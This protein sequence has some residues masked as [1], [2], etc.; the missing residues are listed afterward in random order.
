MIT[1]V[2]FWIKEIQAMRNWLY[3][4]IDEASLEEMFEFWEEEKLTIEKLYNYHVE[5]CATVIHNMNI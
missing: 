5:L 3:N 1:D 2:C 4:E